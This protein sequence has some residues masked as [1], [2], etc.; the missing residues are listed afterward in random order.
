MIFV[1]FSAMVLEILTAHF[2]VRIFHDPSAFTP[3]DGLGL[4]IANV[5]FII[6]KTYAIYVAAS[7]TKKSKQFGRL[8]MKHAKDCESNMNWIKVRGTIWS[9]WLKEPLNLQVNAFASRVVSNPITFT[10]GFFNIDWTLELSIFGTITTYM[11]I[12]LQYDRRD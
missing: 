12:I 11:I 9:W 4:F 8:I 3:L 7:T 5:L 2:L 6:P 1:V 10:C